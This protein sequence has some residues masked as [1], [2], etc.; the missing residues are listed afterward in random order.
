MQTDLIFLYDIQAEADVMDHVFDNFNVLKFFKSGLQNLI[1]PIWCLKIWFFYII[2]IGNPTDKIII[3]T[4]HLNKLYQESWFE[5]DF[6]NVTTFTQAKFQAQKITRAKPL[7]NTSFQYIFPKPNWHATPLPP[8]IL[9]MYYI[10]SKF[11]W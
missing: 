11:M 3:H 8:Y 2:L 9:Q 7:I 4:N 10:F 1:W 6:L 5:Q